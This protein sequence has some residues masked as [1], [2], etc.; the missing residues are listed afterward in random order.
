MNKESDSQ[1]RLVVADT[2]VGMD[3]NAVV[4]PKGTGF[5]SQ[6]VQLLTMQLN[7]KLETQRE[8]GMM[9]IL[10]FEMSKAA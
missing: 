7:G 5:G 4:E 10:R 9:T 2:G 8:K 1:L 3:V 6:L